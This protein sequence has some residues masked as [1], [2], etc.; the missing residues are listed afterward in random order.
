MP[1]KKKMRTRKMFF[2][3]PPRS[4]GRFGAREFLGQTRSESRYCEKKD[5]TSEKIAGESPKDP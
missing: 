5:A 2:M 4:G 3:K 1:Q